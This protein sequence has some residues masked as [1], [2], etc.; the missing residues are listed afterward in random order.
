MVGAQGE[1]GEQG[2]T[3]PLVSGANG[4]TLYNDGT[5]WVSTS[6]LYNNGDTIGIG[7]SNIDA[8]AVFHIESTTKG[9]LFPK[10]TMAQRDLIIS[11]QVGLLIFQTDNS[12]GYYFFDGS[13]WLTMNTSSGS[14]NS[15][16]DAN[17]LLYTSDGF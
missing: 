3:G 10:M 15:G 1:Q 2:E 9:V 17:T 16:S 6:N 7:T 8:S 14:T 4:Q 11:P 12:A 5:D 13:N